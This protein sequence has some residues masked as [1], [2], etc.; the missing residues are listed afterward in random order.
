VSSLLGV[1]G[2]AAVSPPEP[3]HSRLLASLCRRGEEHVGTVVGDGFA[4]AVSRRD[5]EMDPEFS[6]RTLV[7]REGNL[8][9]AADAS[10]FYRAD[11]ASRLAA[12]GVRATGD[13]PSHLILAAYRAWGE[14]CSE[15]LEGEF[16]FLIWDG[17]RR[18]V[19][20]SRDHVGRRALYFARAGDGL[21]VAS[22]MSTI[23][24]HPACRGELNLTALATTVAGLYPPADETPYQAISALPAG[25]C[26]VWHRGV[27]EVKPHWEP[28]EFRESGGTSFESAAAELRDLLARATAERL[29]G[30]GTAAVTMSGGWDST[31]VF[32]SGKQRLDEA[33]Q[34]LQLLPV[35]VSY[36][37]GDPGREDE[38]I[39]A[40]AEFWQVPVQW[41]DI[42]QIPLIDEARSDPAARDDCLAHAFEMFNRAL[43]HRAAGLGAR[44]VLDGNGGDQLFQVS[45]ALLADLFWTGRWLQLRRE[46]V[47]KGAG[48]SGARNFFRWAVKPGLPYP[49]LAALGHLRGGP[50]LYDW[51]WKEIPDWISRDFS[52]RS[53]LQERERPRLQRRRGES[54]ASWENRFLLLHPQ[55]HRAYAVVQELA[56]DAGVEC[57]SPLLDRR[58]IEFAAQRPRWERSSGPETKRLLR[59]AMRGLLPDSVLAPRPFRTGITG[60]YFARSMAKDFPPLL[61]GVLEASLLAELGILEPEAV[62]RSLAVYLRAPRRRGS[63]GRN[64]FL[65][66]QVELWLR[67]RLRNRD[68]NGC[69]PSASLYAPA[70]SA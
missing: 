2:G 6:G 10:L 33:K 41:L 9:V 3:A 7:L 49:A 65:V 63:L 52:R 34:P 24:A 43:F 15:K 19:F 38:L 27:P 68:P 64:L 20:A 5:W 32:A 4:V 13:T 1:F 58:I 66:W 26:L 42:E 45:D 44:V 53:G 36:P 8:V 39:T 29:P 70:A 50:R 51:R 69:C 61:E 30:G 16:A 47:S 35:S 12:Q 59:R 21:V 17:A 28:P 18:E 60:G 54:L 40:I 11:L 48:G 31:A 57:R 23:L 67:A 55:I 25:A 62:R 14:R 46:W 37:V 56:A 22:T